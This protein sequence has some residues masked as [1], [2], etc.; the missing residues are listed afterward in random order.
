MHPPEVP[1]A[2]MDVILNQEPDMRRTQQIRDLAGV[3]RMIETA[4]VLGEERDKVNEERNKLM[5]KI[6]NL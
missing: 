1:V 6:N 5:Q 2:E 4:L 3:M